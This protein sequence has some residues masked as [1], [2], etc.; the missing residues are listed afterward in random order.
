MLKVS[1]PDMCCGCFCLG[2]LLAKSTSLVNEQFPSN[3]DNAPCSC[4]NSSLLLYS[5][6]SGCCMQIAKA[7]HGL[8]LPVCFNKLGTSLHSPNPMQGYLSITALQ[9]RWRLLH[10]SFHSRHVR[11]CLPLNCTEDVPAQTAVAAVPS[12]HFALDVPVCTLGL[13]KILRRSRG[14]WLRLNNWVLPCL[15]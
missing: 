11:Q 8:Q 15:G 4:C 3:R 10:R 1:R 6:S 9:P 5:H 13:R 2:W 12:R 7:T 14:V